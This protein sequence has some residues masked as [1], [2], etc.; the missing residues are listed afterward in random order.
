MT[1]SARNS[2]SSWLGSLAQPPPSSSPVGL[3]SKFSTI[4][5][6]NGQGA[7][8][9]RAGL[10]FFEDGSALEGSNRPSFAEEESRR[11]DQSGWSVTLAETP[12]SRS[13]S[14]KV[15]GTLPDEST[16]S[17]RLLTGCSASTLALQPD[18]ALTVY[19]STS[20]SSLTLT[21]KLSEAL[22]FEAR[23]SPVSSRSTC[24]QV[25]GETLSPFSLASFSSKRSSPTEYRL[26]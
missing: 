7:R 11:E 3:H 13:R 24:M 22:D 25:G 4:A 2:T 10:G 23:V 1:D 26:V 19:V 12:K 17:D 14:K 20:N 18:P 5:L 15:S 6:G 9:T 8:R 16:Q 21:R